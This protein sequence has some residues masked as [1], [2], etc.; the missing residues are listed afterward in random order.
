VSDT[1]LN[2]HREEKIMRMQSAA[3]IAQ[4]AQEKASEEEPPTGEALQV[5]STAG[6]TAQEDGTIYIHGNPF[7]TTPEVIC[8]IC[9]LPRLQHPVTGA[10]SQPPEPGRAYCS[11][12]PYIDKPGC[13]IYGHS[14][15]LEKAT[16]KKAAKVTKAKNDPSPDDSKSPSPTSKDNDKSTT[17]PTGKCPACNRYLKYSRFAQHLSSCMKVGGRHA[18]INARGKIKDAATPRDS[19]ASTP[20]IGVT[21]K[22]RLDKGSEDDEDE[23][24]PKKKK[25]P[26]AKKKPPAGKKPG[27]H[28]TKKG[29]HSNIQRVK[30]AEKRLP[31]Q[32]ESDSREQP[33]VA[34]GKM[35]E[36][37]A[38]REETGSADEGSFKDEEE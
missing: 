28:V 15:D 7:K 16:K 11:K 18:S 25:K 26:F 8:P 21:K 37:V 3:T 20:K 32:S 12:Q 30:G 24:T 23:S 29:V 27:E 34:K 4:A 13:D 38:K 14:L 2:V 1:V 9:R 22:R 17:L 6:A 33:P 5:I 36:K 35:K 10:N 31:G 19:R